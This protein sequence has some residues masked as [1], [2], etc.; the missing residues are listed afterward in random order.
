MLNTADV[1]IRQA[2]VNL[3]YS[4]LSMY[5]GATAGLEGAGPDVSQLG[6]RRDSVARTAA[7]VT[8]HFNRA[9]RE[10]DEI[11]ALGLDRPALFRYHLTAAQ[12]DEAAGKTVTLARATADIDT[13]GHDLTALAELARETRSVLDSALD[14][15]VNGGSREAALT[16]LEEWARVDDRAEEIERRIR[17]ADG[18]ARLEQYESL[19][20]IQGIARCGSRIGKTAL[21]SNLGD[22]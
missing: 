14:A 18:E 4:T 19:R 22:E 2:V 13:D 6:D 3:R 17:G 15:V 16:A 8:R 5:D 1:S 10:F 11:D 9:L 20:A 21:R 12:L 7:H